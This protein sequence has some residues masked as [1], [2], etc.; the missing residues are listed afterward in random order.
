MA[1]RRTAQRW[2][3]WRVQTTCCPPRRDSTTLFKRTFSPTRDCAPSSPSPLLG[4]T[5]RPH[6]VDNRS[7]TSRGGF[8]R[9]ADTVSGRCTRWAVLWRPSRNGS[10]PSS[11][12]R[13]FALLLGTFNTGRRQRRCS[14]CSPRTCLQRIRRLNRPAPVALL[15]SDF[16]TVAPL[17]PRVQTTSSFH[18]APLALNRDSGTAFYLYGILTGSSGL[19]EC[20]RGPP[21]DAKSSSRSSAPRVVPPPWTD[22]LLVAHVADAVSRANPLRAAPAAHPARSTDHSRPKIR[23]RSTAARASPQHAARTGR[24]AEQA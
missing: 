23:F 17:D 11:S 3:R 15:R 18:Y 24:A 8:C 5:S 2:P 12:V 14:S 9:R 20:A 4:P 21:P 1:C 16:L 7:W 19:S 22:E 13:R 6:L 10:P